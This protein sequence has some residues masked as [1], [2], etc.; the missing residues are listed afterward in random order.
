MWK[1]VTSYGDTNVE[2]SGVQHAINSIKHLIRYMK[3]ETIGIVHG[4]ANDIGDAEKNAR[5]VAEVRELA[6]KI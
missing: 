3:G 6:D 4:T 5:L 1:V 2:G